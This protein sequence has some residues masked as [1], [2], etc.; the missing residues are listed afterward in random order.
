MRDVPGDQGGKVYLSWH[1]ARSDLFMGSEVLYYSIWRAIDPASV[2]LGAGEGVLLVG[3]LSSFD[4]SS[5]EPV[6][7]V[8]LS[9]QGRTYF[10]ELVG[11]VD[12]LHMPAYGKP[13]ATL[14]DSTAVCDEYT[15]FQV[16]AHTGVSSVFWS[17][18]AD[19]GYSVDNLSPCTPS[20]LMGEQ[21][22]VPVGLELSWS[23]NVESDLGEYRVYRGGYGGF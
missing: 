4:L 23:R 19:S 18:D 22:Y 7:R 2:A 9:Q 5:G 3:D 11:T 20:G 17:S 16:V 13:V 6:V 21:S 15:Y 8:E 10:W 14:F 1:S 12:A